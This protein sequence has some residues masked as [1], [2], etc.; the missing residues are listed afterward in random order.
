LKRTSTITAVAP[1]VVRLFAA[2]ALVATLSAL[3]TRIVFNFGLYPS[4]WNYCWIVGVPLFATAAMFRESKLSISLLV[5]C[6]LV[7]CSMFMLMNVGG[8]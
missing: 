3:A 2:T 4:N 7:D 6:W 8:S 5:V 1:S